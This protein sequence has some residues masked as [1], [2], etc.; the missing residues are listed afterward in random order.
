LRE[1][2]A[3]KVTM[4]RIAWVFALTMLGCGGAGMTDYK[5]VSER[6]KFDEEELLSA[7][8]AA[9]EAKGYVAATDHDASSVTTREKEIAVSSVPKLSYKYTWEVTTKGGTLLIKATCTQNS[10]MSRTKFEDCGDD[11]PE[12]LVKEQKEIRDDILKRVKGGSRVAP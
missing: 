2:A 5:P 6:T 3:R 4:K 10:S 7:S 9:L 1:D 8:S 11:R 12:R